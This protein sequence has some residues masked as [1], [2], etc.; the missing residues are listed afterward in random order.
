MILR[1]ILFLIG[2]L[3]IVIT[4]ANENETRKN[5]KALSG[6]DEIEFGCECATQTELKDIEPD[7]KGDP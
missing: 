4:L 2:V 6:Y 1:I 3:L 7:G 5:K